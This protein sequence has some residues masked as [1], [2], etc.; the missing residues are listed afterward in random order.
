MPAARA[1]AQ[2]KVNLRLRVLTQES[3]GYHQI[4]TVFQRLDLADEVT[5]RVGAAGRSIDCTGDTIPPAGLGAPEQN[6]A[7]RAAAAYQAAA[8]WPDGFAI[9]IVKRIPVG[10]GLGG[11]SA[12][13]G[14]VLRM[15]DAMAPR[16]MGV[17]VLELAARLGADVAFMATETPL[18][19][20]WGRGERMLGLTPLP[21]RRVQLVV[22]EFAIG[23]ADAYRWLSASRPAYEPTGA[24]LPAA[25]LL[26][27]DEVAAVAEND[28]EAAVTQQHP[29]IGVYRDALAR[30]GA[31][32][33]MLSGSGS[34]VFGVFADGARGLLA[35]DIPDARLMETR[36]SVHVVPVRLIE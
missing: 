7:Y 10:G 11:G 25:A 20:A 18:A 19:F 24:L 15:L 1:A 34:T 36:T 21:R 28:F 13:A 22:P 17:R 23:T 30:A 3:S 33:A 2:A 35:A 9:E 29:R 32:V 16:P 5:I 4:E 14:A 12:D 31:K 8:G 6:L 26:S 27:W